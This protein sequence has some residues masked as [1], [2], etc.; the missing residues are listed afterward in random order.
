MAVDTVGFVSG[1]VY[2]EDYDGGDKHNLASLFVSYGL[3]VDAPEATEGFAGLRNPAKFIIFKESVIE[4]K[5]RGI[6]CR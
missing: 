2:S 6:I 5:E 4:P 3:L 1:G